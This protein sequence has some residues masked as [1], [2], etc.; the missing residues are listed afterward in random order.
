MIVLLAMDIGVVVEAVRIVSAFRKGRMLNARHGYGSDAMSRTGVSVVVA[1]LDDVGEVERRLS[2]EYWRYEVVLVVDSSRGAMNMAA[3]RRK[4]AM[5]RVN[6]PA[7]TDLPIDGGAVLYRSRQRRYRRL[8]VVDRARR[9]LSDDLN[10]GVEVASY[11][12]VIP[13][14]GD[15]FLTDG[16][17]ARLVAE[18]E[19]P[20]RRSCDAIVAPV[21]PMELFDRRRVAMMRRESVV[22]AGGFGGERPVEDMLAMLRKRHIFETVAAA[23]SK[24]RPVDNPLRRL[25][26]FLSAACAVLLFA[27]MARQDWE[28]TRTVLM[29]L[30]AVYVSGTFVA[31]VALGIRSAADPQ[32]AVGP[33]RAI[34]KV[35]RCSIRVY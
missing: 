11:E 27:S 18:M 29:L 8:I 9:S 1:G 19:E 32:Y 3:L 20:G 13:L 35:L 14:A 26:I 34:R 10:C 23:R 12:C 2:S 21:T 31:A 22:E 17:L 28:G 15:M 24:T 4:Y 16:A 5:I 33:L 25:L 30:L 6:F 7:V